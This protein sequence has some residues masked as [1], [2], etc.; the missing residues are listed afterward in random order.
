[1]QL[2]GGQAPHRLVAWALEPVPPTAVSGDQFSDIDAAGEAI[3]R[4]QSSPPF[5]LVDNR[6]TS[7]IPPSPRPPPLAHRGSQTVYH[8]GVSL[9]RGLLGM[10][11]IR[12]RRNVGAAV[13]ALMDAEPRGSRVDPVEVAAES[14]MAAVPLQLLVAKSERS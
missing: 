14:S 1:M 7:V 9:A 12:S 11:Y 4:A 3:A 2:A 5:F 10:A 13:G 8:V 6:R